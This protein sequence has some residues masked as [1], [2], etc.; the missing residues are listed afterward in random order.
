M[1]MVIPGIPQKGNWQLL[2]NDNP[3]P[4]HV[5]PEILTTGKRTLENF[6]DQFKANNKVSN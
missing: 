3:P 1:K 6:I 4:A 2:A 5:N